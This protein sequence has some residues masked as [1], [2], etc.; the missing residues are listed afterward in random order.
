[1]EGQ[2]QPR[3]DVRKRDVVHFL[4]ESGVSITLWLKARR[5][6][7]CSLYIACS[8]HVSQFIFTSAASS[9]GPRHLPIVSL[10]LQLSAGRLRY[11][12]PSASFMYA[13]S[14]S[15]TAAA[16]LCAA[17]GCEPSYDYGQPSIKSYFAMVCAQ[18]VT[19][20]L[21]LLFWGL[22]AELC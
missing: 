17:P 13:K 19:V 8:R 7:R 18:I 22:S 10:M 12:E 5:R 21:E 15:S 3:L 6:S 20:T 14:I 16:G 4:A 11:I 1:M 9:R 2:H